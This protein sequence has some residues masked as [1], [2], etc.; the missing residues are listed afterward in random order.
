MTEECD[1]QRRGE[2]HVRL[3]AKGFASLLIFATCW[4]WWDSYRNH[5][6]VAFKLGPQVAI[7]STSGRLVIASGTGGVLSPGFNFI[8]IKDDGGSMYIS[9]KDSMYRLGFHTAELTLLWIIA[10][11][12]ALYAIFIRWMNFRA[13]AIR[14]ERNVNM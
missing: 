10:L 3:F 5:T 4:L 13:R 2:R 8:R 7:M 9:L 1:L 11:I 6:T 14:R 12:L